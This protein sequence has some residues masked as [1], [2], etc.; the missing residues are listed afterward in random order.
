LGSTL[1]ITQGEEHVIY[2]FIEMVVKLNEATF[3]PLFRKLFDWAFHDGMLLIFD[4]SFI[5]I[6][7]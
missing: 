2:A 7:H 3:R 1:T 6:F 4:G 5:M